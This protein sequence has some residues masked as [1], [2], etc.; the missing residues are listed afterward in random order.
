MFVFNCQLIS[1]REFM[2]KVR[3]FKILNTSFNWINMVMLR[4]LTQSTQN[5]WSLLFSTNSYLIN[6]LMF[7]FSS[8]PST[9]QFIWI[10]SCWIYKKNAWFLELNSFV[11]LELKLPRMDIVEVLLEYCIH[12]W[13][14]NINHQNNNPNR[15]ESNWILKCVVAIVCD[16]SWTK[17]T[18]PWVKYK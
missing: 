5:S 3:V 9:F 4:W 2:V 8:A 18:C 6:V 10:F 15:S 1:G 7:F 17:H 14:G 12:S 11:Y 13:N 16:F